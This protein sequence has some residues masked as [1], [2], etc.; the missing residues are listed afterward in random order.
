M[1]MQTSLP[2]GYAIN[3]ATPRN[4]EPRR[5]LLKHHTSSTMPGRR[6]QRN[7]VF[8]RARLLSRSA[9]ALCK[10][11]GTACRPYWP[12]VGGKADQAAAWV[13]L[14]TCFAPEKVRQTLGVL[15]PYLR[16]ATVARWVC[17]LGRLNGGMGAGRLGGAATGR[18]AIPP[19][20]CVW[21]AGRAA[22]ALVMARSLAPSAGKV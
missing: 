16:I 3:N 1:E 12:Q 13:P 5:T 21:L 6:A 8:A 18:P 14:N 20:G 19:G 17:K 7:T 11:S 9:R 2:G 4:A 10:A 22:R 15:M